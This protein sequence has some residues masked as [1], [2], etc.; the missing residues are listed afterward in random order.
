[1]LLINKSGR[2]Y[3]VPE[4]VAEN[5]VARDLSGSKESIGDMLSTLRRPAET[6]PESAVAGCC[7]VYANYCPNT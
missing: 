3:D 7:N 6:S 5:Y 1:M 4:H 2:I